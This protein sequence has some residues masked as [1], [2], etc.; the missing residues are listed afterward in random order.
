[1]RVFEIHNDITYHP[2]WVTN[3]DQHSSYNVKLSIQNL[4]QFSLHDKHLS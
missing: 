3:I 2:R 1:M 4:K